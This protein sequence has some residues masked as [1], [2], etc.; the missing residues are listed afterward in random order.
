MVPM[1]AVCPMKYEDLPA[2]SLLTIPEV[3]AFLSLSDKAIRRYLDEG[4]L[5]GTRIAGTIRIYRISVIAMVEGGR[6]DRI[7]EQKTRRVISGGVE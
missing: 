7:P 3:G 4:R 5:S 1:F 6:T 2:K